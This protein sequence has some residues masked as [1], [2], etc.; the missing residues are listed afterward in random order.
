MM[1]FDDDEWRVPVD[2]CGVVAM[3]DVALNARTAYLIS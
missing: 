2:I 1:G 3:Y